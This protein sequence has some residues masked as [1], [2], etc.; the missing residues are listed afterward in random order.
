MFFPLAFT[1]VCEGELAEIRDNAARYRTD[2]TVTLTVSICPPPVHRVWAEQNRFDFPVLSDFWPH[3]AVA[4]DYG[5]LNAD[6]GLPNRGTFAVDM[7]GTIAFA[8]M[9]QPGERRDQT[10]WT[11]ALAALRSA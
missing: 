6:S 10:A 7:A 8:E 2:D 9:K 4:A 5:V 1:A 3:G 11:D